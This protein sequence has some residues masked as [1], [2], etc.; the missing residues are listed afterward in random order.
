MAS[1][2]SSSPRPQSTQTLIAAAIAEGLALISVILA[3]T[4]NVGSP[5]TVLAT[6]LGFS[7]LSVICS[8]LAFGL[9]LVGLFR[10]VRHRIWFALILALSVLANPL[11]WLFVLSLA[12]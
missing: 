2:R 11:S 12:A 5:S 8:A 1:A 6:L 7:T 10:F 3:F 9:A 4:I